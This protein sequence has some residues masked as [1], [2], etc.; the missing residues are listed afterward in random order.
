MKFKRKRKFPKSHRKSPNTHTQSQTDP[1]LNNK[2]VKTYFKL[3]QAV[4]H[5]GIIT[6]ALNTATFPTGMMRQVSKLTAFIK[7]SSPNSETAEK[8]KQNTHQWMTQN[9]HILQDHYHKVIEEITTSLPP[10]D[11]TASEKALLF[12]AI[13]YKNR[14]STSSKEKFN[15]II[16]T[17]SNNTYLLVDMVESPESWPPLP[18]AAEP[19]GGLLSSFGPTSNKKPRPPSAPKEKSATIPSPDQNRE[20]TEVLSPSLDS[21]HLSN[22]NHFPHFNLHLTPTPSPNLNQIPPPK[23]NL[24]PDPL[25]N[26]NQIPFP[27]PNLNLYPLP[28]FNQAPPPK[29]NL[30]LDPLSNLNQPS[31]P[32]PDLTPLPNLNLPPSS[33]LN[34]IPNLV[35]NPNPSSSWFL[36]LDHNLTPNPKP[37]RLSH[38]VF[39]RKTGSNVR[40]NINHTRIS[41]PTPDFRATPSTG[42]IPTPLQDQ[43][44]NSRLSLQLTSTRSTI[45]IIHSKHLETLPDLTS[46]IPVIK[47]RNKDAETDGPTNNSLGLEPNIKER[48]RNSPSK[49]RPLTNVAV[50]GINV[51]S[52]SPSGENPLV[53]PPISADLLPE[54]ISAPVLN[55]E[56]APITANV[57]II[58]EINSFETHPPS[59][60]PQTH[61][62]PNYII[63]I[64]FN[65]SFDSDSSFDLDLSLP[66]SQNLSPI[67]MKTLNITPTSIQNN[68]VKRCFEDLPTSISTIDPVTI[69]SEL[70]IQS[71]ETEINNS[72]NILPQVESNIR[73]LTHNLRRRERPLTNVAIEMADVISPAPSSDEHQLNSPLLS[74][75]EQPDVT[76]NQTS[77]LERADQLETTTPPQET[78]LSVVNA[79]SCS[80]QRP[81]YHERCFQK[82]ARWN[83]EVTKPFLII[84]D[85][86][87]ARIPTFQVP[88]MQVDSFPGAQIH[89]LT[90]VIKKLQPIPDVQK[91]ILS[92]GLNN[93]LKGNHLDT[94]KK[95]YQQLFTTV[96]R[97]FPHAEIFFPLIQ[98]SGERNIRDKEKATHI[99][100]HITK[101]YR[102]LNSIDE[103]LFHTESD[104]VHWTAHT[105]EA[106]FS[107]WL[108]QLN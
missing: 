98:L 61:I 104:Q 75:L 103:N 42:T 59:P 4:H 93:I 72:F 63:P 89:H 99:N 62:T 84:G 15:T 36:S 87:L 16:T 35:P 60:L 31:H 105:A 64:N 51:I 10:F 70:N 108:T 30:N 40:P 38:R 28:N 71:E 9:M 102:I 12:A 5:A 22:S 13:R 27:K 41:D 96:K 92:I 17:N 55:T 18:I 52:P 74:T 101:K 97:T 90:E 69:T 80:P 47:D 54:Q 23:P 48:T 82:I 58:Q 32:N 53:S 19:L 49:R 85:S 1:S 77:I 7:P 25:P 33:N 29:P 34:P 106:I 21:P 26:L 20:T 3:L 39:Q 44:E 2:T 95:Q 50:Q 67:Q 86:N 83:L 88:L 78:H 24:N 100:G 56:M 81:T 91:I 37:K 8:V 11:K 45:A 6:E 14:L 46:E 79:P 76:V 107:S 73:M 94:I 65:L 57:E 43:P 66:S 68:G